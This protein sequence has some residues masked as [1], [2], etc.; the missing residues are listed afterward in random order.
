[1]R[2][3][4][5]TTHLDVPLVCLSVAVAV[6]A[7]YVALDLTQRSRESS[8]WNRRAWLGGAGTTMGL[9]I[10][11]MHFIGMLALKMAMPVSYD[12]LL[13]ALSLLAAVLGA[14][15]SLAVVARADVSQRGILSAAAFMGFAVAAMHYL[16][17]ASMQMA[18]VIV[19]NIPLIVL[20]LAIAFGASLFALWL[21]VRIRASTDG[22]GFG[23]RL[24]GSLLLG[25]GVAGLHYVAMAASKFEPS[26]TGAAPHGG[27][28]TESL[29]VMLALGAAITLAVLIGGAGVDQRR[30]AQAKDLSLV[31]DIAHQLAR[32]GDA[33]GPVCQAIREL[34]GASSVVLIEPIDEGPTATASAGITLNAEHS[35]LVKDP[36][37][38]ACLSSGQPTFVGEGDGPSDVASPVRELAGAASMY[39]QPLS[40]EG[41]PVGVLAVAWQ[42]QT[43]PPPERIATILGMLANEIAVAIDRETL[44]NQLKELSR[45]DGL[46][47]LLN[48]RAF[49]E[50]LEN[51][52]A[53]ATRHDRPLSLV[54]LDLDHFKAYNDKHGHQ[55][56]DR[57][58][59]AAAAAWTSALRQTDTI[60]R[61]GGEEFAVIMPECTSEAAA[62]GADR[63]RA[64]VPAGATCSAGVAEIDGPTS[65]AE[66]ISRADQALYAAKA[67]GRDCTR[68][69]MRE[70]L[71]QEV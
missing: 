33:R 64:V 22:F 6:I 69:D 43:R 38:A 17:M 30:A 59:R 66:L 48:R 58:L 55:A 50:A 8:G 9:G 5:L 2:A 52:L 42:Q 19:W 47:G 68:A 24:G 54:M 71:V 3:N 49:D 18:A 7:S 53:L 15:F 29:V 28:G 16:G 31:A 45:R 67:A 1:M 41:P 20:S 51:Q 40:L 34:A 35:D 46:T 12:D 57:L 13:V 23:R 63:L 39:F 11:S 37:V 44:T 70:A 27:L 61:Y 60:A 4:V 62:L 10:W 25:L 14:G 36:H 21:I 65:A 32:I 56:G 26:A